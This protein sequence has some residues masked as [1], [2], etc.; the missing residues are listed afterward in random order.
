MKRKRVQLNEENV[1]EKT[2]LFQDTY[3]TDAQA[4]MGD[5]VEHLQGRQRD[6]YILTM[7]QG[8]SNQEAADILRISR[9]TVKEYRERAIKFV[10]AFCQNG[11]K[12]LDE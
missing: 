9:N 12:H 6:V 1:N 2:V 5:A 11:L 4:L 8:Y 7:R 10:T 3:I